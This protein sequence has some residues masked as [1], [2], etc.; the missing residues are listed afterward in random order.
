MPDNEELKT[1]DNADNRQRNAGL[2]YQTRLCRVW[3][4]QP[5]LNTFEN[6]FSYVYLC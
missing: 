2:I 3:D 4:N 6:W 1:T 5:E